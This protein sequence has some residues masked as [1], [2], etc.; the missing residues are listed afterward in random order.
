MEKKEKKGKTV[1]EESVGIDSVVLHIACYAVM[2][3]YRNGYCLVFHVHDR[4][5][6]IGSVISISH[7][8]SRNRSNSFPFIRLSNFGNC[9]GEGKFRYTTLKSKRDIF[10]SEI[11]DRIKFKLIESRFRKISIIQS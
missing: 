2:L 8:A 9:T 7:S 3:K 11:S 4:R 5:P 1:K 6:K 10:S